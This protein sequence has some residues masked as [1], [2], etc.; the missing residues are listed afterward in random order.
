M[1]C[2]RCG[3][4]F[5]GTF[6]PRCGGA[7]IDI[8]RC[9]ICGTEYLGNF[10]AKCGANANAGYMYMQEPKE[11]VDAMGIVSMVLGIIGLISCGVFIIPSIAAIIFGAVDKK[12]GQLTGMATAG[13]I[14]GII[15]LVIGLGIWFV[16]I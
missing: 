15:G 7:G 6:C 3:M 13:L 10:C 14:C 16:E 11:Q 4:D 9:R 8:K 5:A 2:E 1:R 12:R